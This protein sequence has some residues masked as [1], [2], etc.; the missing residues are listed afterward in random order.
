VLWQVGAEQLSQQSLLRNRAR[1]RSIHDPLSQQLSQDE[2][3]G[4][5]QLVE[6][7]L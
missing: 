4:L 2:Q 7:E 3:E 6:Q 5:Q 1:S